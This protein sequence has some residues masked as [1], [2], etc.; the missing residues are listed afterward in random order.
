MMCLEL[1]MMCL[2]KIAL[3][4]VLTANLTYVS[5]LFKKKS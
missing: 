4:A 5:P 1:G 2:G 3:N